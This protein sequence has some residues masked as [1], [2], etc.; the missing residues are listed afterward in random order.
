MECS[1]CSQLS[2]P[3]HHPM[4]EIYFVQA[5]PKKIIISFFFFS[6]GYGMT[7]AKHDKNYVM[8][9]VDVEIYLSEWLKK[10]SPFPR[11]LAKQKD[12][13]QVF[14]KLF[15]FVRNMKKSSWTEVFY[16]TAKRTCFSIHVA[17]VEN[18]TREKVKR[19][20]KI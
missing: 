3:T 16:Q 1:H 4:M 14:S 20:I 13:Y 2:A 15:V 9:N 8:L 17:W 18:V 5:T 10:S 12:T 7:Y 11:L 19:K 6:P